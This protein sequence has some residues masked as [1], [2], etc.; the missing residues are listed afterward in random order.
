MKQIA[1]REAISLLKTMTYVLCAV[2]ILALVFTTVNVTRF[3][4]SR[5]VPWPI[6]ILL[7]PMDRHRPRR[8]SVRRRAPGLLGHHPAGLVDHAALGHRMHRRADELLG[9]SVARRAD[10][11][12]PGVPI[13]QPCCCT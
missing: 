4:T 11:V 7:D 6:A 8:R 2:G 5:G 13:R 12:A 1:A 3:A 10:R 9:E